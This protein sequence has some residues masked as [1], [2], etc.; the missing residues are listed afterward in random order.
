MRV[1]GDMF[2]RSFSTRD[3]RIV[4]PKTTKNTY[5]EHVKRKLQDSVEGSPVAR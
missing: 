1:L 3:G 4:K 5:P 2:N